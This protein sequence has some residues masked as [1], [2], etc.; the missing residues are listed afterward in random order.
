MSGWNNEDWESTGDQNWGSAPTGS[1]PTGS[2][3][4]VAAEKPT[5][6]PDTS[7]PAGP[8]DTPTAE[9]GANP[10]W[11]AKDRT[12]YD[13]ESLAAR[14]GEYDGNASVY[15]WDGE[16]GDIGPEFPELENELFGPPEKRV[17][18]VQGID[19]S[20]LV[21]QNLTARTLRFC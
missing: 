12:A 6:K 10:E 20:T 1:A 7:A 18:P 2:A 14:S 17:L 4:T 16:E 11:A 3:P 21:S 9:T 19:F 13:Y 5:N 8:T 15:H